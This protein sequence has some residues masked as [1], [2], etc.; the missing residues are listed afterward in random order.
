MGPL[1]LLFWLCV[2]ANG[3]YILIKAYLRRSASSSRME[4]LHSVPDSGKF[5]YTVKSPLE[6]S[7]RSSRLIGTNGID[8][9]FYHIVIEHNGLYKYEPGQYCGV[10]PPGI[11]ERTKRKYAPRSYSLAPVLDDDGVDPSTSFSL[12]IRAP[13]ILPENKH[14]FRDICICSQFLSGAI[15]GTPVSVTGPFGKFVLSPGDLTGDRNLLFIATGSGIVPYMGFLK[16]ILEKSNSKIMELGRIL[17]LFGVQ[18][19]D[20]Y[21][22]RDTI[23]RY[24]SDFN[25]RLTVIPCYSRY[26]VDS[27]S[28]LCTG[29]YST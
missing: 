6:C 25:G 20:T 10:I 9:S 8:R 28:W 5:R 27:E 16:A 17:L 19:P 18:S 1:L 15:P 24:V 13:I 3:P 2:F 29:C 12:G 22:Y 14:M 26:G 4:C 23:E 11:S 7:I 21:L